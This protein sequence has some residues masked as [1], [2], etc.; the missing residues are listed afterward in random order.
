MKRTLGVISAM[1]LCLIWLTVAAEET[2]APEELLKTSTE[3]LSYALGMDIAS[4]LETLGTEIDVAVFVQGLQD[5]FEGK[6]T[7]LTEEQAAEIKN[8][9][10]RRRQESRA[11]EMK[12]LAEEN[13]KEG[14]AFLAENKKK[15]GVQT[16][17]SGLQYTVLDEGKGPKPKK[18]DR[19]RVHY[20]GMLLDGT[21]F[22]SSYKRG[23]PATFPLTGVIP[24][25]TEGLQLMNVGSKYKLFVPSN[26]AYGERGR[27]P[28]IGPNATL[29]FEV[30]LLGIEE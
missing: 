30:E 13:T 19:V 8:D 20:R 6:E 9:F 14:E 1:I 24:G 25:W 29:I 2:K 17:A 12:K 26:I 27:P 10:A 22:D 7:L 18:S 16:T 5:S 23:Q 4:F 3:K 28:R 21:E 15:K 11:E